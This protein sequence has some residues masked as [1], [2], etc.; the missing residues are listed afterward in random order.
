VDD[1]VRLVELKARNI[2][3]I[4]NIAGK[5]IPSLKANPE[6]A[7]TELG[8]GG[9]SYSA[10]L[11]PQYGPFK[12]NLKLR[13]AAWYALDRKAI[14]DT[15]GRG[16]ALPAY[17]Y[18]TPGLPGYDETLPRYEFNL[19]KA[20]QLV[21]DAGYP[22]GVDVMLTHVARPLD[23]QQAQI[24]KQMWDT[25]GLRTTIDSIE[26]VAWVRK[27]QAGT[28]ESTTFQLNHYQDVDYYSRSIT[29]GGAGNWVGWSDPETDKCMADGRATFDAAK[30]HQVYRTCMQMLQEKA[31]YQAVWF[32]PWNFALHKSVQGMVWNWYA[33]EP[34]FV[35]LDK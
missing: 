17:Y 32:R 33:W 31:V 4:S 9:L 7:Y 34:R 19:D 29:T 13:Q 28:L 20:K 12:D 25:A 8:S 22:N 35:W 26:R 15:L 5:D 27:G 21:K 30:R 2:D 6:V 18:W 3:A 16:D 24:Y 10:G 14:A 23:T 1:S 11:N